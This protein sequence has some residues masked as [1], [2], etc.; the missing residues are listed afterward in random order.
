MAAINWAREDL[1]CQKSLKLSGVSFYVNYIKN[2]HFETFE[3]MIFFKVIPKSFTLIYDDMKQHSLYNV[4]R[5][6]RVSF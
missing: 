6:I 3:D 1:F 2:C 5:D 4:H